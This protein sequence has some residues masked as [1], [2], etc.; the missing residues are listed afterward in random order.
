M[1]EALAYLRQ[2]AARREDV[3]EAA[4]RVIDHTDRRFDQIV[5]LL[6][7]GAYS[8]DDDP[9][10][11]AFLSADERRR[12]AGV[13]S[14]LSLVLTGGAGGR[15]A[16]LQNGGLGALARAVRAVGRGEPGRE[17]PA[18]GAVFAPRGGLA[19]AG[20]ADD[21]RAWGGEF[22]SRHRRD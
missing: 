21:K 19:G 18:A 5:A 16:F 12:L 7:G 11:Y 22:V 4:G 17:P 6:V 20:Y 14:R 1:S 15:L 8:P 10:R 9:P 13:L 3:T 2:S